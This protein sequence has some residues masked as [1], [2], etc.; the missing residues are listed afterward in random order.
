M[1]WRVNAS[2]GQ[3]VGDQ[4]DTDDAAVR[5]AVALGDAVPAHRRGAEDLATTTAPAP[6]LGPEP[7]PEVEVEHAPLGYPRI[8]ATRH[9]VVEF[10]VLNL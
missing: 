8:C 3:A 4:R 7:E 9:G 2:R 10:S 6:G 5:D 1:A